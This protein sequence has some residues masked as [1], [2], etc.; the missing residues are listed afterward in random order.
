MPKE[1][2]P[3]LDNRIRELYKHLGSYRKVI[4]QLKMQGEVVSVGFIS[5]VINNVGIKRKSIAE[6]SEVQRYKRHRTAR[7]SEAIAKVKKIMKN[8][9]PIP[10]PLMAKKLN[11]SQRSVGRIVHQDLRLETRKK[12]KFTC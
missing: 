8:A 11:I 5:K 3:E 2:S 6:G 1:N 4:A 9:N 10:Q 12:P 7:T